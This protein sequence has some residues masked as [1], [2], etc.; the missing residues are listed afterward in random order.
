MANVVFLEQVSD[1]RIHVF[2]ALVGNEHRG[3]TEIGE[4]FISNGGA[5]RVTGFTLDW[6]RD[7]KARS[8]INQCANDLYK[9]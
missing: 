7:D 4:I 3:T 5:N 2:R 8:S 9:I 1:F 6:I